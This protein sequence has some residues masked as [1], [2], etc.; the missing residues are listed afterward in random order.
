MDL[1]KATRREKIE[2]EIERAQARWERTLR[3]AKMF[4]I[5]YPSQIKLRRARSA[6]LN[7][8]LE[9][10]RQYGVFFDDHWRRSGNDH[11]A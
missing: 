10:E 6:E 7:A 1:K 9:A 8:Q 3:L 5:Y 4:E 2:A 11:S